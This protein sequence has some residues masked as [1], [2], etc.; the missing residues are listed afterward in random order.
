MPF[1]GD[2][3]QEAYAQQ[4]IDEYKET[5]IDPAEVFAQSFNLSDILYWIRNEPEFGARAVYLDD[6]YETIEGFDYTKP[7]TW[8]PTM[9]DLA[10]QGVKIV[11]PP[12]WMLVVNDAG[13]IVPS[14]YARQAKE[15][16]LDIITWTLER[17]GTL[18]G[19]GGGWYYQGI[20]NIIDNSGD[21]YALLDVLAKDVG[22]LGVFSDWPAT[23]SYYSTCMKLN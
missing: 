16:G 1:E 4:M 21:I 15:A 18:V 13:R 22:V 2:Y 3:T 6:R 5:G 23:V 11:A 10:D 7:E 14:V 9:Q 17:S 20:N 19:D 12:M 8:K